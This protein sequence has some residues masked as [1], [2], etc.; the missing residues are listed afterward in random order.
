M[1]GVTGPAVRRFG[2]DLPPG[3]LERESGGAGKAQ[4][5]G[6]V[7]S[8]PEA[9]SAGLDSDRPRC[10]GAC[11]SPSTLAEPRSRG[12]QKAPALFQAW[13]LQRSS[14]PKRGCAPEARRNEALSVSPGLSPAFVR[15]IC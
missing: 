1:S 13:T 5:K 14:D 8:L 10:F 2:T 12:P 7:I 3:P 15:R 4:V 9:S 11:L 6:C